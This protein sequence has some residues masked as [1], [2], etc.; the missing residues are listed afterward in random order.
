[1]KK[2]ITILT[3]LGI[4][5][6][7]FKVGTF[8]KGLTF[9]GLVILL[10]ACRSQIEGGVLYP[11]GLV[12]AQERELLMDSMALMLIVVLPV[13]VMSFTFAYKYREKKNNK[14][15]KPTWSHNV[16]LEVIW[17]GVPTVI[18]IF[19]GILTWKKTHQLDPYKKIDI[20]GPV[21]QIQAIALSWKWLFIY[22]KQNIATV[23]YLQLPEDQQVEFLITADAPMSAFAIPQLGS[24]IYAMAGMR[25]RL[26]LFPLM[27]GSYV[28]MNTQYSGRGFADMQ[29]TADVVDDQNFK[30]WV[31][32]V[33]G[34]NQTLTWPVYKQVAKPSVKHP[35]ELYAKVRPQ[36]FEHVMHQY[37]MPDMQ[38]N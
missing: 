21:L 20:P 5:R 6:N 37:M 33:R 35:V 11:K 9:F 8:L 13:I 30:Q 23:N 29:F 3:M 19:L 38:M 10:T 17:W 12:A 36:L 15:Y 32:Q 26:H 28:G 7:F 2:L 1:M 31:K 14:D 34:A 22:P 4:G 16:F 24:Q 25:T 18:I 27:Q